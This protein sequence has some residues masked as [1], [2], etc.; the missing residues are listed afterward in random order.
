MYR[1]RLKI[2]IRYLYKNNKLANSTKWG[3]VKEK[4][5]I[6]KTSCLTNED[7]IINYY[8]I[9][10]LNHFFHGTSLKNK[11]INHELSKSINL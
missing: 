11:R 3:N 2:N 7:T 4:H 9:G 6:K 5:K 10:E 8:Y 1:N